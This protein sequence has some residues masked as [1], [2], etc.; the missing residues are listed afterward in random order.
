MLKRADVYMLIE[1]ERRYQ[2]VRYDPEQVLSSG[3]TRRDRDLD[4]TSGLVLLDS[5]VRKAQDDWTNK[6][7]QSNIPAM[8][9]VAK[10]AAIAV[11]ILERAGGSEE[12]LTRGLR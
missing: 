1:E 12:L 10:I 5:Y 3:Q 11:R 2:D 4:V 6:A 7:S 9:Q 8:Q